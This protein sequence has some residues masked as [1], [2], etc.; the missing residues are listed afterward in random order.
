MDIA[1]LIALV[2]G[3]VPDDDP[4]AREARGGTLDLLRTAARPLDRRSFAPGH[5]TASG[6]VL[7]PEGGRVLLVFHRRLGRWLQPG[8][9]VEPLDTD[10]I[11]A[12]RREVR[13][14]TSV[15][16]DDT[17]SPELVGIDVHSI[18]ASAGEPAHLHHDLVFRF[19][20]RS[21]RLAGG[22]AAPAAWCPVERLEEYDT[23]P[24]LRR[25]A[26]RALTGPARPARG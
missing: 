26:R 10:I 18:P 13:E 8:G 9:H 11:G 5:V 20:A 1:H 7:S 19:V 21:D 22:E 2:E 23:D 4:R 17:V 16:L 15:E 25:A 14:E 24:P 3:F 12:A 6:L